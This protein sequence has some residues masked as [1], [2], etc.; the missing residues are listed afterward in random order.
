[1]DQNII[2]LGF[3]ID[4]IRQE[5]KEVV[6]MYTEVFDILAKVDGQKVNVGS[7]GLA[8]LT[9]KLKAQKDA[10]DQLQAAQGRLT[11]A[12]IQ[13][14]KAAQS[15]AAT[16]IKQAKAAQEQAKAEALLAKTLQE[17]AKA[18]K[19]ASNATIAAERATR[20]Q[21]TTT[22]AAER[23]TRANSRAISDASNE[24]KQFAAAVAEM[25]TKA[26]NAQ[27][28]MGASHPV[29]M[30]LTEDARAAKAELDRLNQSTGN[31]TGNVGNYSSAFNG[32]A[33][34][35]RGLRGPTKLFGEALGIGAQQAD[36]FRIVLEHSLQGIASFFRSKESKAAAEAAD[37][38][39]TTE[40]TA[41][42]A[43][44]TVVTTEATAATTGLS[45]GMKILA[46]SGILAVLAVIGY[47]V[48]Q[49]IET[50]NA[51][52]EAAE[53][54][55]LYND[56]MED[57]N[58]NAGSQIND[59]K[60]LYAV[61]TDVTA[62]TKDRTAAVIALKNEFPDYFGQLK[63]ETIENGNAQKSYEELTK[64][65]LASSRAKSVKDKKDVL[66]S[67][68]LDLD[69]TKQK[70]INA[71]GAES[72]RVTSGQTSMGGNAA[73]RSKGG[74][75]FMIKQR[76]DEALAEV[77]KA[78]DAIDAREKL[79]DSISNKTEQAKAVEDQNQAHDPKTKAPKF[80]DSAKQLLENKMQQLE[81]GA[82]YNKA[83]ADDDKAS[84][85]VRIA[86]QANYYRQSKLIAEAHMSEELAAKNVSE[87][88]K[89]KIAGDYGR[90]LDE[91]AE[92][93]EKKTADLLEQK[94]QRDIVAHA[95]SL[96]IYI[97]TQNEASKKVFEDV[98]NGYEERLDAYANF[99]EK[100]QVLLNLEYEAEKSKQGLNNAELEAVEDK[101]EAAMYKLHM[102]GVATRSKIVVS[103]LQANKDQAFNGIDTTEL[104]K[105]LTAV[106]SLNQKFKNGQ[107][108]VKDYNK[109][110]AKIK[111]AIQV[112]TL[113]AQLAVLQ[114]EWTKLALD[115]RVVGGADKDAQLAKLRDQIDKLKLQLANG[116]HKDDADNKGGKLKKFLESDKG[117][118][119]VNIGEAAADGA[120]SLIDDQYDH[121]KNRIQEKINLLETAK[122]TEIAGIAAS[123]MSAQ[124]KAAQIAVIEKKAAAEKA[125]MIKLQKEEDIKKAKFDK[126]AA[127]LKISA[128]IGIDIATGNW[129][130]AA[131]GA[132]QLAVVAAKEIPKYADGTEDHKGGLAIFGEA[133]AEMVH[134]PN[135]APYLVDKATM[136]YLPAHTKVRP[137]LDSATA[138]IANFG[139]SN[140]FVMMAQING[141]ME[142]KQQ[143]RDE[144]LAEKIVN[145]LAPYMVDMND[146]FKK[147]QPPIVHVQKDMT[148]FYSYVDSQT[149]Y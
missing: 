78:L 54:M 91:L 31:F 90:K 146:S 23:A 113:T 81:E 63:N 15:A 137:L 89:V 38:A 112:E 55:K 120:I 72:D 104:Q 99:D 24:Y 129:G 106:E 128:A 29:A 41:A 10:L 32:Y 102:D 42:Q 134:E 37:T 51:A 83:I 9:E 76:K 84:S 79:L 108:S 127:L 96:K 49:F 88:K 95:N 124:E 119:D 105:E 19:E 93:N 135:K 18:D 118:Q 13:S 33:N 125:A 30:Q 27:I 36:Q 7:D 141:L 143:V 8:A 21:A 139:M 71:T 25:A 59:L 132:I 26:K 47:L 98:N 123:S 145:G 50:R 149:D 121:E 28:V 148:N 6:K 68:R 4:Q 138:E 101:H 115:A 62:S 126:A 12:Q 43:A 73:T 110:L 87:G 45:M 56:T 11:D 69:E 61:A 67:Q 142:G 14:D 44:N 65:I 3:N 46:G 122:N 60:T 22:T 53:T 144:K 116:E 82:K 100:Q 140:H 131:L 66:E 86:A 114:K 1:M 39:R 92:E 74:Q 58:K 94:Q 48:Y 109:E 5:T 57:A 111:D 77:Q 103:G 97:A 136:G 52:R 117:K 17:K 40:N 85:E 20:A 64:S 70:I 35:L 16:A 75:L 130:A 80:D 2:A 147:K 34:T 133:G 107:V